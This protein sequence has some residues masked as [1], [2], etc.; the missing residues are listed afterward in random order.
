M[1]N[2]NIGINYVGTVEVN[3]NSAATAFGGKIILLCHKCNHAHVYARES[4][5]TTCKTCGAKR[6][7]LSGFVLHL[8]DP[9]PARSVWLSQYT[10]D[11]KR[12][13]MSIE[14]IKRI[15]NAVLDE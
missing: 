10:G 8:E 3:A 2:E 5:A 11:Y 13:T 6:P 14:K 15:I 1:K 12:P 9:N 4:E 7:A